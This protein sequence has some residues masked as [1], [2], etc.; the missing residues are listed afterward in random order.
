MSTSAATYTQLRDGAWGIRV[1]GR[2]SENSTVIVVKK[3]G[4]Q[5]SE[6]VAKVLWSG[7]D[8]KTGQTVS[9]CS[10]QWAGSGHGRTS[11]PGRCVNCGEPC[12]P[13]YR[14]C[15]NCVDG[16]GNAHGGQ[17]YYDRN[18]NFVLGDDD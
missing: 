11:T 4:S 18:G 12:K 13:K 14:R 9:L 10:I 1:P 17:S 15:R 8:A 3:D 16:G 6:I 7:R 2:A 5:K